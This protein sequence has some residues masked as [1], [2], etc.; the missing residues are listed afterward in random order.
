MMTPMMPP[1][2]V[3]TV[4]HPLGGPL[5]RSPFPGPSSVQVVDT[6][7]GRLADPAA[8]SA[9]GTGAQSGRTYA[10]TGASS[11]GARPVPEPLRAQYA[12]A[13]APTL[14]SR[15]PDMKLPSSRRL[16]Q[17]ASRALLLPTGGGGR[18]RPSPA[19][20]NPRH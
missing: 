6:T 9:R 17:A 5:F 8:A 11:L 12:D 20:C 15:S 7:R 19:S 13:G 10:E 14:E 2:P 1:A 16:T 3:P 4:M 18:L